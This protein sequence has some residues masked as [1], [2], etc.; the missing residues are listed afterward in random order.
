MCVFNFLRLFTFAF[1]IWFLSRV[2]TLT[3]DIGIAILSVCIVCPLCSGIL[4]KWLN[5]QGVVNKFWAWISS[6]KFLHVKMSP[7][8]SRLLLVFLKNACCLLIS[9]TRYNILKIAGCTVWRMLTRYAVV[10][11][12]DRVFDTGECSP[13]AGI[14]MSNY[15][16][17][18]RCAIIFHCDAFGCWVSARQK[19]PSRWASRSSVLR[20]LSCYW[21]CCIAELVS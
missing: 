14:Q 11:S 3:H 20:K 7:T 12:D 2:S 19:K 13:A 15:C 4:C 10:S 17:P 1:F 6:P 21:K 8:S 9:F 16:I 18:W 5:I